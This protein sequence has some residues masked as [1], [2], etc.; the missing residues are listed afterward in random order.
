M[1]LEAE[2]WLEPLDWI[3]DADPGDALP[4]DRSIESIAERGV[5]AWSRLV[6]RLDS[7][8]NPILPGRERP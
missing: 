5:A 2:E 8:T 7:E 1:T 4:F 6:A 3:D